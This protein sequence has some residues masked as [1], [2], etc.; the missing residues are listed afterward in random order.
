MEQGTTM[1]VVADKIY[2]MIN[3]LDDEDRNTISGVVNLLLPSNLDPTHG[4]MQ[5]EIFSEEKNSKVVKGMFMVMCMA[6]MVR[7]VPPTSLHAAVNAAVRMG[8]NSEL[9]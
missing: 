3:E 5:G 1:K 6:L 9:N 2:S 8:Q 7:G 4:V